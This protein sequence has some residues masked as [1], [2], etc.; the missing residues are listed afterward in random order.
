M[1]KS[2]FAFRNRMTRAQIILALG[3]TLIFVFFAVEGRATHDLPLGSSPVLTVLSVAAP[4]AI[5]WFI[6]AALLGIYRSETI[7]HPARMLSWTVI[8]WLSGGCI[9]LIARAMILQRA[10]IP[11]FAEVTLGINGALLLGWRLIFSLVSTRVKLGK[12]SN[13]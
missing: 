7:A 12:E 3:D 2:T 8:T 11:V 5:P 9:G 1:D 13:D 6:M 10:V 4:F